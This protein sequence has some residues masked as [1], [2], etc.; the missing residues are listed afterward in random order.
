MIQFY[1]DF[2]CIAII[3]SVFLNVK[4]KNVNKLKNVFLKSSIP[5][6][7]SLLLSYI[8]N[9]ISFPFLNNTISIIIYGAVM[10]TVIHGLIILSIYL[11]AKSYTNSSKINQFSKSVNIIN[12]SLFGICTIWYGIYLFS[13]SKYVDFY[14]N[15]LDNNGL[16]N[17]LPQFSTIH[18]LI[19]KSS[20]FIPL[21]MF[22]IYI[23]YRIQLRKLIVKEIK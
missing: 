18:T 23:I 8:Y 6:Y 19:I 1:I 5:I 10:W 14:I 11:I 2:M 22:C 7:I 17:I 16:M 3:L 13:Y 21:I 12:L 20:E 4:Q 15:C 9:T